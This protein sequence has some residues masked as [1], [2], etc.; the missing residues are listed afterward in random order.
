MKKTNVA[1]G[2][3]HIIVVQCNNLFNQ[4]IFSHSEAEETKVHV[5]GMV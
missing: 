4:A 3:R 2:K 1:P 5:I